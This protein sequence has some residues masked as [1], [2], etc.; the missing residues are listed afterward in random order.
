MA[1]QVIASGAA[2]DAEIVG[3]DLT[4]P[5]DD[6]GFAH[7]RATFY[8]PQHKSTL[9]YPASLPRLM[10]R[11]TVINGLQAS[12]PGVLDTPQTMEFFTFKNK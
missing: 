10:H 11:T 8:Q 5:L 1:I 4:Q 7:I 3:A 2:L 12:T 9:D 6:A